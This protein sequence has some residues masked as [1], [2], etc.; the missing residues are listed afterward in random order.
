[1]I[2]RTAVQGQA[3]AAFRLQTGRK[4][5]LV[6]VSYH[7]TVNELQGMKLSGGAETLGNS[8]FDRAEWFA[9]LAE[10]GGKTPFVAIARDETGI[11]ALPLMHGDGGL[12]QL[13]NW[14]AFTW[15]PLFEGEKDRRK[16]ALWPKVL[17]RTRTA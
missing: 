3:Q 4:F 13:S 2:E 1:M 5:I 7:D 11:A 16:F 10:A 6:A 12:E 15:R 17:R 14:Y 8:P 9:L